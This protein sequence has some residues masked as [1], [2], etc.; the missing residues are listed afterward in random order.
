MDTSLKLAYHLSI[1]KQPDLEG[2]VYTAPTHRPVE[3]SGCPN[4][5]SQFTHFLV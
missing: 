1:L 5:P 3:Q 2:C 4:L